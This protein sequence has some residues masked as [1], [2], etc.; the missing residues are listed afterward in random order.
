MNQRT[1][2]PEYR[3]S[4]RDAAKEAFKDLLLEAYREREALLRGRVTLIP[5]QH[6]MTDARVAPS[7]ADRPRVDRA[8]T[9]RPRSDTPRA[10][11][12]QR[13]PHLREV[14]NPR[15]RPTPRLLDITGGEIQAPRP[16][17]AERDQRV[18]NLHARE[19]RPAEPRPAN[20]ALRSP[21]PG[22]MPSRPEI[23]ALA[24]AA[25]AVTAKLPATVARN[26]VD[27]FLPS[28]EK[29]AN[30]DVAL[31][32]LWKRGL[33][34]I[35]VFGGALGFWLV[36]TTMSSAVIGPGQFVV[37]GSV[38]KVQHPTGGVVSQLLVREGDQV[39]QG[40]LLIRLDET[41]MRSNYQVVAGQV[42]ELIG[43]KVRLEAERDGNDAIDVPP[44]LASRMNDPE[45]ARIVAAERK[46]FQARRSAR[47]GQRTQLTK[48]ITQL[49]N[50]IVGLR[51]QLE[52][53]GRESVIIAD[54]LK[55]V[56]ELFAKQLTPIMRLSA[57]ERQ[58]VNLSGQ[59]G[60]LTASIAQTEGKIAEIEQ[61]ILNINED[62]RAETQKELREVQGKIA[63]LSERRIA[64]DDTL[65]RVEIRAPSSGTVHQLAV[66]TVGG[67]I[68]AAE[69][70]M[71]IVPNKEE[72]IVEAKITPQDRDQLQLGQKVVVK[73]HTSN[74]RNTPELN[75]TLTRI[76]ADVSKESNTP[77]PYYQVWVTVAK[78][79]LTRL[80]GVHIN[81]GMQVDVFIEAGSRSPLSYLLRPLTDQV[82]RAFRER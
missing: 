5:E 38:K 14:E 49:Q 69:P 15:P 58:A 50:E 80:R 51:A 48:R 17:V 56:R 68:S 39:A 64:A 47:E 10:E 21:E 44:E 19:A 16:R 81:A 9:E 29:E 3:L 25:T 28:N 2:E 6:D 30:H 78:S 18:V 54:E 63:E 43:R 27:T 41:V 1:F 71:V 26:L 42:D 24:S 53:N 74:Q 76:A 33:V 11:R 13:P 67:V 20:V 4:R 8:R 7:H 66:H 73:V 55:G 45:V 61:Q 23:K 79:E 40:D 37:D 31:Q 22:P 75:G 32:R 36:A 65:K 12:P 82:S 35:A 62:L 72:L 70:A 59:K 46:L 52:A 57:L 60:Q 77:A 34:F